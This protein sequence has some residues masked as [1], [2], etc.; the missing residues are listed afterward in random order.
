MIIACREKDL[1][2]DKYFKSLIEGENW[3]L[4]TPG[5][6]KER[7]QEISANLILIDFLNWNTTNANLTSAKYGPYAEIHRATFICLSRGK[8]R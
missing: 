2:I 1:K 6:E 8:S 7:G 5:R 3:R 4:P